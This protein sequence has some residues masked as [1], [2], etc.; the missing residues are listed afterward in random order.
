MKTTTGELFFIENISGDFISSKEDLP[1]DVIF[2]LNHQ[3]R[4]FFSKKNRHRRMFFYRKALEKVNLFSR[5]ISGEFIFSKEEDIQR[6]IFFFKRQLPESCLLFK[7]S[8]EVILFYRKIANREFLLSI[9]KMSE[10]TISSKKYVE[11]VHLF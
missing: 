5:K 2:Y 10:T 4:P 6:F 9:E 11:R 1:R 7:T 3:E 8:G